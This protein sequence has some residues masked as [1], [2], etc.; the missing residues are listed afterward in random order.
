MSPSP[1]NSSHRVILHPPH[2]PRPNL[3]RSHLPRLPFLILPLPPLFM[4]WANP[5]LMSPKS[6]VTRLMLLQ[7]LWISLV[8]THLVWRHPFSNLILLRPLV[9]LL[10]LLVFVLRLR[11]LIL[12]SLANNEVLLNRFNVSIFMW[13]LHQY[14]GLTYKHFRIHTGLRQC[15]KNFLHL[16]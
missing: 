2:L 13:I 3:P 14:L 11:H 4:I 9:L 7:L 8:S 6:F 5:V 12:W 15:K 1:K 16:F 10:V